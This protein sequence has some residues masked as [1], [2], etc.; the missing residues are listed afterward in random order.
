VVELCQEA[1]PRPA[2][3]RVEADDRRVADELQDRG[4]LAR[5]VNAKLSPGNTFQDRA[6]A[7]VP[8]RGA[9]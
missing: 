5:H 4:V 2:A 7:L 3:D 8:Q 1:R 6:L 9:R